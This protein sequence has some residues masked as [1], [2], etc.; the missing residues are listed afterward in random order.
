MLGYSNPWA[1]LF[2]ESCSAAVTSQATAVSAGI[3]LFVDIPTLAC[4]CRDAEGRN[5]VVYARESCWDPAPTHIK[6][7][8]ASLISDHENGFN[9][10]DICRK[11]GENTEDKMRAIMDPVMQHGYA[12]TEAVGS[13]LDYLTTLFDKNAG[14]CV[15]LI[16]SPYT[17]AL[18]PEPVDYFRGCAKTQSCRSTCITL[19]NEFESAKKRLLEQ[20]TTFSFTSTVNKK[21]FSN[22]DVLA[23]RAATPFE[24]MA[25]L[26][27]S[28]TDL[29]MASGLPCCGGGN[30]RDRCI[31]VVGITD[32]SELQVIEYCIPQRLNIGTHEH[33]RWV[34]ARSSTWAPEIHSVRFATRDTLI[35]ALRGTVFIYRVDGDAVRVMEPLAVG[36]KA[37]PGQGCMHRV[38]WVFVAPGNYAIVYGFRNTENSMS[39]TVSVCVRLDG[40]RMWPYFPVAECQHNLHKKLDNH[41][42]TCLGNQCTELLML[43]TSS[44]GV[45]RYCVPDKKKKFVVGHN[46]QYA[47]VD[48]APYPALA[49]DLGFNGVTS[50]TFVVTSTFVGVRRTP[51]LCPNTLFPG[52]ASNIKEPVTILSANPTKTSATWLQLVS[53]GWD[54]QQSSSII[55]ARK[56]LSQKVYTRTEIDQ[57]CDVD[58]CSG[59]GVAVVQR[60]CFAAQQCAVA[61]CIGTVVNL[62]R[63]LCSVGRL[64]Q[65]GLDVDLAKMHG[66]WTVLTDLVSFVLRAACRNR[67]G[68]DWCVQLEFIDEIFFSVICEAKNGIIASMSILTSLINGI[69]NTADRAARSS[70]GTSV[71]F[72]QDAA[73]AEAVRSMTAAATTNFLSQIA[74]GVL[75]P[76]IV[77]KKSI[78]CHTDAFLTVFDATGFTMRLSSAK[79]AMATNAMF[80]K[81]LSEYHKESLQDPSSEVSQAG[82]SAVL[83]DA[84][85]NVGTVVAQIPF[86]NVLHVW[87]A[88]FAYSIGIVAGLQD[89]VGTADQAHCNLPDI[90]ANDISTCACGDN[91]MMIPDNVAREGISDGAFWCTGVLSLISSTGQSYLGVN[92]YTYAEITKMLADQDRYLSCFTVPG[93]NMVPPTAPLLNVQGIS[94]F[95]VSTRC[96]SNYANSQWDEGAAALFSDPLPASLSG[97]AM[98]QLRKLRDSALANINPAVIACLILSVQQG[99]SNNAC[100]QDFLTLRNQRRQVFFQYVPI[101]PT[102][103]GTQHIAACEVFTGL[104]E[105]TSIDWSKF[106]RC[107]DKHPDV[108]CTT[109]GM[110]WAGR[111]SNRV[112]VATTHSRSD[113]DDTQRLDIARNVLRDVRTKIM[114]QLQSP[115]LTKWDASHLEFAIFTAEG[116]ALHQLFDTLVLGPYAR[117]GMWPTDTEHVLPRLD[118]Y[119]DTHDGTTREFELPCTGAALRGEHMAPFT[120][121]SATRRS[122]I[123]YFM[124]KKMGGGTENLK[125]GVQRAVREMIAAL[126]TTWDVDYG[127]ECLVREHVD[128]ANT[129]GQTVSIGDHNVACC[130]PADPSGFLP[131]FFHETPYTKLRGADIVTELFAAIGN[132]V[133]KDLW[134]RSSA[135]FSEYNL[136]LLSGSVLWNKEQKILA[137]NMGLL[138]TDIPLLRYDSDE[139]AEPFGGVHKNVSMWRMCHGFLQQTLAT[140]PMGEDGLPVG[141]FRNNP[142]D[143]TA[144]S[145]EHAVGELERIVR[146]MTG[147]AWAVS[148]LHYSHALRHIP[149]DSILCE[150]AYMEESENDEVVSAL[151]IDREYVDGIDVLGSSFELA[152]LANIPPRTGGL[153]AV[154]RAC[155]CGWVSESSCYIPSVVCDDV[156]WPDTD[157]TVAAYCALEDSG[158]RAVPRPDG[159]G[160]E[161]DKVRDA[162]ITHWVDSWVCDSMALSESWGVLNSSPMEAW[163][164]NNGSS[165]SIRETLEHGRVSL[166]IGSLESVI[167]DKDWKRVLNPRRTIPLT[168]PFGG[169]VGQKWCV[170]N[171][172]E[173][174]PESFADRFVDELF[175]MAQG[176]TES[177]GLAFCLRVVVE[178]ARLR[179]LQLTAAGTSGEVSKRLKE[180]IDG[181]ENVLAQWRRRC[182]Q[183]VDMV[184]ICMLR[185]V[186]DIQPVQEEKPQCP[187][188]LEGMP[189]V[190]AWLTPGCVLHWSDN[191]YFYPCLC[192]DCSIP[193]TLSVVRDVVTKGSCEMAINPYTFVLEY[194]KKSSLFWATDYTHE[195]KR[196]TRSTLS[197]QVFTIHDERKRKTGAN[198]SQLLENYIHLDKTDGKSHAQFGNVDKDTKWF[199]AEGLA[200]DGSKFC[201]LINDWWPEDWSHPV[202]V[203]VTTPCHKSETAYRGFDNAFTVDRNHDPPRVVYRHSEMRDTDTTKNNI[204]S[205]GLCRMRSLAMPIQE[206]NTMR[207]CTRMDVQSRSDT[208]VPVYPKY[209]TSTTEE[210]GQ[211]QFLE[212]CSDSYDGVPWDKNA[213]ATYRRSAGVVLS[214]PA[215]ETYW[216]WP[217]PDPIDQSLVRALGTLTA[218]PDIIDSKWGH[219]GCGMYPLFTCLTN[220]DCADLSMDLSVDM[221]CMKSRGDEGVCMVQSQENGRVECVKHIDCENGKMCAGDGLC[222]RS[223]ASFDNSRDVD[224]EAHMYGP[225]CAEDE[226]ADMYGHSP[227]EQVPDILR[228]HGLCSH[229][230]WY[231]YRQMLK[232]SDEEGLCVQDTNWQGEL[233]TQGGGVCKISTENL[234]WLYTGTHGIDSRRGDAPIRKDGVLS[235]HAHK[236]DR[237]FM[238]LDGYNQCQPKKAIIR[239]VIGR[240]SDAKF[241]RSFATYTSRDNETIP[242]TRMPYFMNAELGFLGTTQKL[243]LDKQPD[244]KLLP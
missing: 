241:G 243:Q 233:T 72:D 184:G 190:G 63:P 25:M 132:F 49:K 44:E 48:S 139:V 180:A 194:Q 42:P 50:A 29:S 212:A 109:P 114:D 169:T 67:Y 27:V 224:V 136:D 141:V 183:Q 120:C 5:F 65:A 3:V 47:C 213:S 40:P 150:S 38:G 41:V 209:T 20:A 99:T 152:D 117:A 222:V 231:E 70:M 229:R 130:D 197:A 238:H 46:M 205:S 181:R 178:A 174:L 134:T 166:R 188:T 30:T 210:Q 161:G 176:V 159:V 113:V 98:L 119:R 123:R 158:N 68:P 28:S 217:H 157:D 94:L 203:H 108:G 171:Q 240:I 33:T 23:G 182:I 219:D 115:T 14:S 82:F 228:A 227:W 143:P 192:N 220:Q 81:C 71:A 226:K 45:M 37:W 236:C 80:G 218:A 64:L 125:Q 8:L 85:M 187:F 89:I 112:P 39:T 12:A 201:D 140:L 104:A 185:G 1:R 144:F 24:V 66:I 7:L 6:P 135:P 43:P 122:V 242:Y 173:M 153:G 103:T 239:D 216:L 126:T 11:L 175:P 168:G 87:D 234:H 232:T 102:L 74:L 90:E 84:A 93:C 207:F 57:R 121:G 35:V 128:A 177:A 34:V 18:V 106:R 244:L 36:E 142:L 230:K 51:A 208:A 149:S 116:D 78:T 79:Y 107:L 206:M 225:G 69:V 195:T 186:F 86:E 214:R 237:D 198:I 111:S 124:G 235:V 53:L 163:M 193:S 22:A 16:T 133:E 137:A 56:E 59:C 196:L 138:R 61:K 60:A 191:R 189:A 170:R 58:D 160:G 129:L 127:C 145:G 179:V 2:R 155:L 215:Q 96:K 10:K 199:T 100:L 147:Q 54:R 162:V 95:T 76:P 211:D 172:D 55:T 31:A 62:E 9:Q 13:S 75:Y 26:E 77:F 148:P 223:V 32:T 204:G 146:G 83:Q 73:N 21:F 131:A 200:R 88:F 105:D 15:D 156:Y 91:P 17:M 118:W 165:V 202:G 110:V 221:L 52:N 164:L 101:P 19:F 151:P 167:G 97:S 4:M 92:P 154:R